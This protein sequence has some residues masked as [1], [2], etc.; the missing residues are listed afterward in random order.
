MSENPLLRLHPVRLRPQDTVNSPWCYALTVDPTHAYTLP[1]QYNFLATQVWPAA[2]VA[3]T[4]LQYIS[5][6]LI[7]PSFRNKKL[8]VCEFGCGPGL[9]SLTFAKT[10]KDTTTGDQVHVIATDVDPLALNL[11]KQAAFEQGLDHIV[12]TQIF[13]LV[14]DTLIPQADLYILSDVFESSV[15]ARGAARVVLSILSRSQARVWVFVQSD[16]VQKDVFLDELNHPI[17]HPSHS[18]PL[19]DL[20]W[21]G[22]GDIHPN[23]TLP[24]QRLWLCEFDE[25]MVHY[26]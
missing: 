4:A 11:V 15:I 7:E 24:Q 22:T 10:C 13:D 6:H 26:V 21:N 20:R 8:V 16:R 17:M 25:L 18:T 23:M 9:P 3:A 5:P 2:R 14:Q 1:I 12:S 19:D